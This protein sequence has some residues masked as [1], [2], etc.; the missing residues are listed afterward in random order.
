[1]MLSQ[2]RTFLDCPCNYCT[3]FWFCI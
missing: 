3:Y 1:M 2:Y